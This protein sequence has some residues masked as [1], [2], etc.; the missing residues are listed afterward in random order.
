MK[1]VKFV[2]VIVIENDPEKFGGS[3]F[4]CFFF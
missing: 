4:E 1:L 3:R 2:K